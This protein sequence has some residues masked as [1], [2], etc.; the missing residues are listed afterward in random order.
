MSTIDEVKEHLDIVE[1]VQS[2]IHLEKAGRRFKALC[3]FHSEKTASFYVFPDSQRWQCFGACDE[4]GDVFSFVEKQEGWDFSTTLRELARKAGV[5]LEPLTPEARASIEE[6]RS[7]KDGLDVAAKHFAQTL[8]DTPEALD[9]AHGRGW[10][11]EAIEAEGLGYV[12]GGPLPDLKNER[13][14][15]VV[16]KLSEWARERGGALVYVHRKLGQVV[17]LSGR[18][19]R[20]KAHYNPPTDIAGHRQ[21]YLNSAY[22]IRTETLVIS[23]GQADA[24]TLGGWEI[25]ALAMAGAGVAGRLAAEL[26]RHVERGTTIYLIPDGDGNTDVDSLV[27]TVGPLLRVVALPEGDDVNDWA[28]A[29]GDAQGFRELL[30]A[31]P[32]WLEAEIRRVA[33]VDGR[34]RAAER[35]KLFTYLSELDPFDLADHREQVKGKLGITDGQFNRYLQAVRGEILADRRNGHDGARYT[36]EDGR[37]CAVKHGRDGSQYTEPLCNFVAEVIEDVARDDGSTE[38][39]REFMIKGKLASG[40]PLP[41]VRVSAGKFQGMGWITDAWGIQAV[42]RAGWRTRDLLREAIQVLSKK[43]ETRH[44]YTHTGWRNID[45]RRVYLHTGGG[46]GMSDIAVD[47][48]KKELERYRLPNQPRDPGKAMEAS[49]RF[50]E[51][52]PYTVTVP[53]WAGAFLAPLTEILQ[54]NFV[55]WLYGVTGTLKSTLAALALSHYGSF[56]YKTLP[57]SWE[58]TAY[59]LEMTCFKLK[60]ALLVIDDFAPQSNPYKSRVVEG[61][62]EYIVRSVGNLSSRGRLNPDLSQRATHPPRCLVLST[63]EQLPDG[64]SITARMYTVEMS[65]GDVDMEKLTAA[66]TEAERY[67]HAMAGYLKWVAE[68]WDGLTNELPRHQVEQ[69][70]RLREQMKGSH[71]RIPD[72][73]ATLY[74]G[75]DLG[76]SYA[77]EVGTLPTDEAEALRARGWKALMDGALS[78]GQ[79]VDSERPTTLFLEIISSLLAQERAR[80]ETPDGGKTIGGDDRAELLGWY[81]KEHVYLLPAS[82]NTVARFLRDEGRRF[83]VKDRT[84]RKHLEEEGYLVRENP[85]RYTDVLWVTDRGKT[86]RVLKLRRDK[87]PVEQIINPE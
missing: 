87:A 25:P 61:N 67:P 70:Q 55:L 62:A 77:V 40:E 22:S 53:I 21:P 12:A 79:R 11:D 49:L 34:S 33:S 38:I 3:P 28:Q 54:P 59:S 57:E 41:P 66:Q 42:P 16:R 4:G 69:R 47:L 64:Q 71:L 37:L 84:L 75:F 1:I 5:E 26:S 86:E 36:I 45:G 81:D 52:A 6:Q 17:Y 65:P 35:R 13:A 2:Y 58:T 29:S 82:Y 56:T 32:A 14:Q 73:L 18:A 50:L 68:Q 43:V 76:L 83:P 24:V 30:D 31:A 48:E 72:V 85:N 9:Y 78:Q 23:E 20:K 10:S 74:L 7:Y 19:I 80:L 44:V 27:S 46:L 63:G 8:Q 60:D 51:V 39:D 15:R